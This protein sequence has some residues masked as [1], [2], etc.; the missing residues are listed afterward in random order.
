MI[1]DLCKRELGEKAKLVGMYGTVC[2][3]CCKYY[4]KMAIINR[5]FCTQCD[6]ILCEL[7]NND[8]SS[9]PYVCPLGMKDVKWEK[10]E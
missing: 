4:I 1:C 5:Y 3:P 7:L 6:D 9:E 2:I 10:V 8:F